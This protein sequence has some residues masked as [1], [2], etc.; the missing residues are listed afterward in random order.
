MIFRALPVTD[1]PYYTFTNVYKEHQGWVGGWGHYPYPLSTRNELD[2]LLFNP[3]C[4]EDRKKDFGLLL[5]VTQ[6]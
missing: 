6:P 1:F 4:I 3:S 5:E 2:W